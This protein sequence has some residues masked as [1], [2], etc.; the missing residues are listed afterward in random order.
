MLKNPRTACTD[1]KTHKSLEQ[2]TKV[3]A[4]L[5]I[6]FAFIGGFGVLVSAGIAEKL[7]PLGFLAGLLG[8]VF[9]S[10]FSVYDVVSKP[11]RKP[12]G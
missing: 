9:V 6:L 11:P 12:N 1:E 2:S 5:L 8:L 7:T 4:T 3:V 10:C